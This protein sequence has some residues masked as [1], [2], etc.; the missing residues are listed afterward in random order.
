[1]QERLA[2]LHITFVIAA[3]MVVLSII[4]MLTIMKPMLY[5][6]AEEPAAKVQAGGGNATAPI[7]QFIP[8]T[9]EINKGQSVTWYNP[10]TVG[11]PHTVTFVFDNKTLTGVVAPFAISNS[12]KFMPL[13]PNS[14][15]QPLITPG[16]NG[17]NTLSGINARSYTA[18]AI[19]SSGNVKPMTPNANY[20]LVGN[21]KYVNSGYFLP[22]GLEKQYPGSGNTFTVKFENG[23]T[24]Y[25]LC[26]LHPWMIGSVKVK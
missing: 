22:K 24:Y 20:T 26:V 1:V 23:G 15:S 13:P 4:T 7:T 6:N 21:E 14:N 10:T 17:M 8:Q 9:V 25:Y 18:V 5:T 3:S 12:T 11:E 16:Q 2:P 19:D